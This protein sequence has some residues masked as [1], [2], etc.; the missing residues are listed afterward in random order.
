MPP[1]TKPPALKS[2]AACTVIKGTHAGKAGTIQDMHVSATGQVTLT[3]VQ[4]NG[5]RF[6]TLAR[7]IALAKPA[8]RRA[9]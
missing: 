8:R 2:G 5:E 1:S 4:A 9:K 3:V 6:K 7:N